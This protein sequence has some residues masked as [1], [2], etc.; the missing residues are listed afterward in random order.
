M[1]AQS[2][3]IADWRRVNEDLH[4]AQLDLLAE[5]SKQSPDLAAIESK[6]ANVERLVQASSALLDFI[7]KRLAPRK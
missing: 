2:Q 6:K 7:S 1:P 5:V 3:T 4:R